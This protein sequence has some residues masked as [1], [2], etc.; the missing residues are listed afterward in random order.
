MLGLLVVL[1][2][3]VEPEEPRAHE[4]LMTASVASFAS[5]YVASMGLALVSNLS[6]GAIPIFSG[7][8]SALNMPIIGPFLAMG[9][10]TSG[11]PVPSLLL[12]ADG[13]IQAA[14]VALLI[15]ALVTREPMPVRVIAT[16]S[17]ATLSVGW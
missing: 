15:V 9:A 4:K 5:A 13:V 11:S 17:S 2:L 14:S 16:G 10:S 12:A 7:D 1:A 3:Q 8:L 6:T